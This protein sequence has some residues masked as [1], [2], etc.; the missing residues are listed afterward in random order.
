MA[1]RKKTKLGLAFGEVL[2]EARNAK[3][4]TQEELAALIDYSRVQIGY[5]ETGIREPSLEGIL[6]LEPALGLEFGDLTRRTA[7]VLRHRKSFKAR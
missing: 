3:K 6:R 1:E 7:N 2:R 4:L 5:L